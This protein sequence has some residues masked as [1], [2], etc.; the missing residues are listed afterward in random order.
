MP[1]RVGPLLQQL[2]GQ[3]PRVHAGV[4][5]VALALLGLLWL[6]G[7]LLACWLLG[8][9]VACLL[10]LLLFLVVVFLAGCCLCFAFACS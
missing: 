1:V 8:F 9:L 5:Q 10:D 2:A 6:A 7:R 4:A 3:D